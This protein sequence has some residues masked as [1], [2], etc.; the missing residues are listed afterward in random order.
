MNWFFHLSLRVVYLNIKYKQSV[1]YVYFFCF[2]VYS[3]YGYEITFRASSVLSVTSF[4]NLIH[5]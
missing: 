3:F 4:L 5:C 1:F 2:E